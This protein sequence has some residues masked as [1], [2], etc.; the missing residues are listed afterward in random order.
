[1]EV[2]KAW[3]EKAIL[4][5]IALLLIGSPIRSNAQ[6]WEQEFLNPTTGTYSDAYVNEV[7]CE[8]INPNNVIVVAGKR[9]NGNYNANLIY[10]MVAHE[11]DGNGNLLNST[12]IH[13][14]GGTPGSLDEHLIPV[15]VVK[16]RNNLGY[17]VLGFLNG[18]NSIMPSPTNNWSG[19]VFPVLYE[20][21]PLLNIVNS[22]E[23]HPAAGEEAILLDMEEAPSGYIIATGYAGS[24]C[25]SLRSQKR[26]AI[27]AKIDPLFNI[28]WSKKFGLG[29]SMGSVE[30]FDIAESVTVVNHNGQEKYFIGGAL[31]NEQ[32]TSFGGN[33]FYRYVT[34]LNIAILMDQN[35]N[36][37][38]ENVNEEHAIGVDAIQ[39]RGE[40]IQL[41]NY[42]DD[43][44]SSLTSGL[45]TYDL[46][47]GAF[48]SGLLYE[49]NPV[50]SSGNGQMSFHNFSN[51]EIE[52]LPLP[53]QFRI[54]ASTSELFSQT[55]SQSIYFGGLHNLISLRYDNDTRSLSP[56]AR[57]YPSH[58]Q[59]TFMAD[60]SILGH[61]S[62]G[63]Y[64]DG[65][66]VTSNKMTIPLMVSREPGL[67]NN[68]SMNEFF[69]LG[70]YAFNAGGLS[71]TSNGFQRGL[72]VIR[73]DEN[74]S[75]P[76][77]SYNVVVD[78][79]M[80]APNQKTVQLYYYSPTSGSGI[81]ATNPVSQMTMG[82]T[83]SFGLPPFKYPSAPLAIDEGVEHPYT[84]AFHREKNTYFL[85][86]ESGLEI[87]SISLR[88]LDGRLLT[89]QFLDGQGAGTLA[90]LS[91]ES[92]RISISMDNLAQ[93]FYLLNFT[94]DKKNFT[95]KLIALK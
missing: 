24:E 23:L 30:R 73:G 7:I 29:V 52:K 59:L 63:F 57:F 86:V 64:F 65:T 77:N 2:F 17:Y 44:A 20:L 13:Y 89:H 62:D 80:V 6:T 83:C 48:A 74:L 95:E 21:D 14:P 37:L 93:G 38:W 18:A 43:G 36:V 10:E 28:A 34:P 12:A 85:D 19:F 16:K 50:A 92:N 39:D 75:G 40:I 53:G 22:A 1:M 82:M 54:F 56:T 66:P 33:P 71:G 45:I 5:S 87:G 70:S 90:G 81:Y 8:A 49:G 84:L 35:G 27:I 76:C 41:V 55:M 58:T 72:R 25:F 42:F 68:N 91:V 60:P 4:Y 9:E 67:V 78:Q 46:A 15:K 11:F 79:F 88:A 69:V 61:N 51:L 94:I 3:G 32:F 26:E 31:S 47:T